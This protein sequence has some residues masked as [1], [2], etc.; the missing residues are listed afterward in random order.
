MTQP[1][2]PQPTP[3]EIAAE[4][5]LNTAREIETLS[6]AEH[7]EI[8]GVELAPDAVDE[9]ISEVRELVNT[10]TVTVDWPDD[11][12]AEVCNCCFVDGH[13]SRCGRTATTEVDV[14]PFG[15]LA[16]SETCK[17]RI[18]GTTPAASA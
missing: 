12:P 13:T 5:I 9:L 15:V 4:L 3:R 14:P 10:A 7:L 1:I 17:Q 16:V 8:L 11:E 18:N 2:E 6:I